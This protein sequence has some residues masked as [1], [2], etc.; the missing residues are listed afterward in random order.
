MCISVFYAQVMGIWLFLVGLAMIVHQARFKKTAMEALSHPALVAFTGFVGLAV[1]LLIVISHNIWVPAWPV[2]VT[3]IG[4]FILIQGV[5]RIFWPETF[6]KWMK[7]SMAK[8]GFSIWS[9][10]WLII[11]VYLM[12]AGFAS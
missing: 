7:D 3:L 1:G 11:G 6:G 2:V 8:T 4:W 5:L 12:W 10:A 9:W